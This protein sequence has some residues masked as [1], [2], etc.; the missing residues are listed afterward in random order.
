MGCECVAFDGKEPTAFWRVA[1]LEATGTRESLVPVYQKIVT[2][3]ITAAKVSG[4]IGV[5]KN[6][7]SVTM[8]TYT[9]IYKHVCTYVYTRDSQMKT[10]KY[11]RFSLDSPSYVCV[12][13]RMYVC[14]YACMHV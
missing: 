3:V 9:Y 14:M 11:L 1:G 5:I 6:E 2:V 12:Y 10:L 13:T 4:L 7:K 8:T